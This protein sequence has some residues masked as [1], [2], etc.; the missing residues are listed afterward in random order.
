MKY[1]DK[2]LLVLGSSTYASEIVAYARR[3]G[4]HTIVADYLNPEKSP[5]KLLADESVFVSTSD[6][7][8]LC[9]LVRKR[10]VTG[11]LAGISEFNLMRAME[12]SQRCQLPFYCTKEQWDSIEDKS[13]FRELCRKHEVPC[14][15]TYYAG[16]SFED[17]LAVPKRFPLVVKPVDCAASRGVRICQNEEELMRCVTDAFKCS[18]SGRVILEEF[19]QGSEFTAHFTVAG[20]CVSFT[21]ADNRYPVVIHEGRVTS[22]PVARIYPSTFTNEIIRE[23]VPGISRILENIGL[24]DAVVFV[25][26]IHNPETGR[27]AVFEAG[28]RSAAEAPCRFL[29]HVNGINYMQGLVD[30]ALL[31]RSTL[32]LSLDDPMLKGHCCAV[33][34]FIALGGRKVGAI[35]GLKE[36]VA[37]CPGVIA[38]ES[39]YPVGFV[40][41]DTDT[42]RQLMIRFVMDC[43]SRDELVREI[44]YLNNAVTVLDETGCNMV[45]RPDPRVL[46]SEPT[47]ED[48]G[49][50]L[51]RRS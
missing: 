47:F 27:F 16:G 40:T 33:A 29:E 15:E 34:S 19:V 22:I 12:V 14:P 20:G 24:S 18:H 1:S 39:R 51:E 2:I 13:S 38:Y 4:A 36:A 37:A 9:D 17:A 11:V 46:L 23:I 8:A 3:N 49:I 30:V 45:V 6:V 32:D 28:L 50:Y 35:R 26:G 43:S 21:C 44:T 31:G 41:P 48:R 5:A 25:Q 42:L 10:E 7:D